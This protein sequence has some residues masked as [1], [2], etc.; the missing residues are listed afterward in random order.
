[1]IKVNRSRKKR[2]NP[3]SIRVNIS[4]FSGMGIG[5]AWVSADPKKEEVKEI[6]RII[7]TDKFT[8]WELTF[9][10]PLQNKSSKYLLINCIY[11]NVSIYI[12]DRRRDLF[13]SGY[14]NRP[15]IY[16]IG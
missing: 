8:K 2:F 11:I 16:M 6:K 1:M 12:I 10:T 5:F 13:F 4:I 15:L 9:I 14:K 7:R 3:N